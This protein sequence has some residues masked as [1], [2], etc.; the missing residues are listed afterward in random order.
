M[1]SF[2]VAYK[3]SYLTRYLKLVKYSNKIVTLLL[4]EL[5]IFKNYFNYLYSLIIKKIEIC[6]YI[7]IFYILC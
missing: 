4:S 5:Q 2:V 3:K 1:N 6:Y 7:L